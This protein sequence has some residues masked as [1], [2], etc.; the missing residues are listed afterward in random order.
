MS[1]SKLGS[2][3]KI[4]DTISEQLTQLANTSSLNASTENQL[5]NVCKLT[6]FVR[7]SVEVLAF[8]SHHLCLTL[9]AR[10]TPACYLL[11]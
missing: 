8:A 10:L 6:T 5:N 7:D 9:L 3:Y 4:F 11:P 1:L 2:F